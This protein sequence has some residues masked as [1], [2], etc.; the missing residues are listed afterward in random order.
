MKLTPR[1][2]IYLALLAAAGALLLIE[3][4]ESG[5]GLVLASVRFVL[6]LALLVL[7]ADYMIHGA[8]RLAR[9]LGVSPFF[10][11]VT[12]VAFGTSAPELFASIGATLKNKG[13]LAVGNVFGSNIANIGLILGITA[14]IRPIAVERSAV[15]I[16]IP[17]MLAA[18]ALACLTL[19][20]P[21][22]G[23]NG[24]GPAA[25]IGTID[26]LILVVGLVAFVAWNAKT[27]RIDPDDL[28]GEFESTGEKSSEDP[29]DDR[30]H[31]AGH[32]VLVL[33]GLLGL[34]G[35]AEHLVDGATVLALEAGV[36]E[37]IIG[38]TLVAIGTSL[39]E[40][41]LS[42]QAARHGHAE[43]AVG[44]VLGSNVFNLLCVLGIASLVS[45]LDV[46]GALL[47]RDLW[48]VLGFSV[49]LWPLMATKLTLSRFEGAGLVI[50]YIAYLALVGGA[51]FAARA[52]APDA[53]GLAAG[54]P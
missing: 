24:E 49:L 2:I 29:A 9:G 27:G 33:L 17:L 39:P 25:V 16:D 6:G 23:S 15:R 51:E 11:G 32:T 44:N 28:E 13:Q 53:A 20:D 30:P 42:V 19:A 12:V 37:A 21:L 26:G 35:G 50:A 46:P 31:L 3:Q 18:T 22:F 54:A 45:P 43:I 10:I 47:S 34:V 48:I 40:L 5:L 4:P 36:S 8:V 38:L 52:A 7:G 41:V 1:R 14:L